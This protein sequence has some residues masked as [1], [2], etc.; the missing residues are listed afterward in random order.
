MKFLPLASLTA[1]LLLSG[2]PKS[3]G[4]TGA[5]AGKGNLALSAT[6]P[7]PIRCGRWHK[8]QSTD[9][10]KVF[11]PTG[12]NVTVRFRLAPTGQRDLEVPFFRDNTTHTLTQRADGDRVVERVVVLRDPAS[13]NLWQVEFPESELPTGDGCTDAGAS[14]RTSIDLNTWR[15]LSIQVSTEDSWGSLRPIAESQSDTLQLTI[16]PAEGEPFQVPAVPS[17]THPGVWGAAWCAN[18]TPGEAE[19]SVDVRGAYQLQTD[20]FVLPPRQGEIY[21]SLAYTVTPREQSP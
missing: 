14:Q 15:F 3:S 19:L 1:P 7:A 11:D 17:A 2:C 5:A 9:A 13:E 6:W 8:N 18:Q 16:T 10:L 21:A 12:C 20:T 4:S